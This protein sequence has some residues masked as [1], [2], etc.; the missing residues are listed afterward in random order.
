[1]ARQRRPRF[2]RP[3]L[4]AARRPGRARGGAGLLRGL[5]RRQLPRPGVRRRR[6]AGRYVPP[7][8][9]EARHPLA[10]ARV[11]GRHHQRPHP[12][13]RR[14]LPGGAGD[15]A[16]GRRGHA[17]GLRRDGRRG[18]RRPPQ[19]RRR[20]ALRERVGRR[21]PRQGD[22]AAHLAVLLGRARAGGREGRRGH[23]G[24]ARGGGGD[25]GPAVTHG[26]IAALLPEV[27]RRTLVRGGLLDGLLD[28]MH[29]LHEP[30]ERVLRELPAYFDPYRTPD[31][32]VPYLAT[33]LD[34]DRFLGAP[35]DPFPAGSGRLR[36]LVA[37]AARLSA[38][39]GTAAGLALFLEVA[40]GLTGFAVREGVDT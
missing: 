15:R 20:Q 14:R 3:A 25:G 23:R 24:R 30:S 11:G 36:E 13:R 19:R 26:E 31:A 21:V 6:R 37:N 1:G 16:R 29:G 8:G 39:R 34:L 35:S 27:F 12:H 4:A 22:A 38:L 18:R 28:V 10:R 33:W 17:R 40:T 2:R 9:G 5:A 7:G 32:F